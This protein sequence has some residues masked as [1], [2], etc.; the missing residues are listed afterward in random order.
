M[1]G[2]LFSG[3]T[4]RAG[5]ILDEKMEERLSLRERLLMKCRRI[6][7]DPVTWEFTPSDKG[8]LKAWK[9]M[10]LEDLKDSFVLK[11]L[12]GESNLLELQDEFKLEVF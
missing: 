5:K 4:S 9:Q 12:K 1:R 2:V 10:G 11:V 3:I 7:G 6:S 8:V